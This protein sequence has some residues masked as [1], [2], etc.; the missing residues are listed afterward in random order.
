MRRI[1]SDEEEMEP[2]REEE[3]KSFNKQYK[4]KAQHQNTSGLISEKID[5]ELERIRAKFFSRLEKSSTYHP[6][7]PI[8]FEQPNPL[9]RELSD[10]S[11]N[12]R[13][14]ND[15]ING[16]MAEKSPAERNPIMESTPKFTL[17]TYTSLK[18][19]KEAKK[20]VESLQKRKKTPIKKK[21]LRKRSKS[22]ATKK[23]PPKSK[24]VIMSKYYPENNEVQAEVNAIP[25]G[26]VSMVNKSTTTHE[27]PSEEVNETRK[28]SAQVSE[29][30]NN[31][32][33]PS[34]K[35]SL[36]IKTNGSLS[37]NAVSKKSSV[38]GSR[39][40]LNE[41]ESD[42]HSEVTFDPNLNSMPDSKQSTKNLTSPSAFKSDSESTKLQEQLH[43][44]ANQT[45]IL[46]QPVLNILSP[47]SSKL[48][49]NL[50][51][52]SENEIKNI[53]SLLDQ[54]LNQLSSGKK[55]SEPL[56]PAL[57][58]ENPRK[59]SD[60]ATKTPQRNQRF[61]SEDELVIEGYPSSRDLFKNGKLLM[62]E[63]QFIHEY[64]E[65]LKSSSRD[66]IDNIFTRNMN[67]SANQNAEGQQDSYEQSYERDSRFV[68]YPR[69][70]YLENSQNL[71]LFKNPSDRSS[72]IPH[73]KELE[74]LHSRDLDSPLLGDK[75]KSDDSLPVLKY[76]ELSSIEGGQAS[77]YEMRES[78][79]KGSFID[80]MSLR[81]SKENL[82]NNNILLEDQEDQQAQEES[83]SY[84]AN[85]SGGP[86]AIHD[87]PGLFD[88]AQAGTQGKSFPGIVMT[89]SQGTK[90]KYMEP[91]NT[92][93]AITSVNTSHV[94]NVQGSAK[95]EAAASL[96]HSKL[97]PDSEENQVVPQPDPMRLGSPSFYSTDSLT[98]SKR[99]FNESQMVPTEIDKS[100]EFTGPNLWAETLKQSQERQQTRQETSNILQSS[101]LRESFDG[102]HDKSSARANLVDNFGSL[103]NTVKTNVL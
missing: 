54:R 27:Q 88:T 35:K 48:V 12:E 99:T 94:S 2:T 63:R 80:K 82:K 55:G 37:S 74:Y 42:I 33:A 34:H 4:T 16:R 38:I 76:S 98:Y 103:F 75:Y 7:E 68:D 70:K 57:P 56:S 10:S 11:P 101:L 41:M 15:H 3:E 47:D 24:D 67:R 84:I 64:D 32:K 19:A 93:S 18:R 69:S 72:P 29:T 91:S 95:S 66:D 62:K 23:N 89:T 21:R 58:A 53:K 8:S 17:H 22:P 102:E 43:N 6:I 78:R 87:K 20:K 36:S 25:Q 96:S 83:Y 45:Q 30:L 71:D 13:D 40:H 85:K 9:P 5:P 77:N 39:K 51:A 49:I 1:E 90:K 97:K 50:D 60:K 31:K 65:M 100:S 92:L 14:R 73:M 59:L 86:I 52:L 46:A 79:I 81:Q 61:R 44:T 26:G 28:T